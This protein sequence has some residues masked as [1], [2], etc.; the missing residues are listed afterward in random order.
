MAIFGKVKSWTFAEEERREQVHG[1]E[2]LYPQIFR[3]RDPEDK[4]LGD[5]RKHRF[6]SMPHVAISFVLEG[7]EIHVHILQILKGGK[8]GRNRT[9]AVAVFNKRSVGYSVQGRGEG[10]GEEDL[11]IC[12]FS[13]HVSRK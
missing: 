3:A 9:F 1:E 13:N 8:A 2:D 12:G 4:V 6:Q 10:H 11:Y 5:W 7:S